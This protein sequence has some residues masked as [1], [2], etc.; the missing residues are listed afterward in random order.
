VVVI[1]AGTNHVVVG[2][3]A[4]D[5]EAPLP[6]HCAQDA[7]QIQLV[8]EAK[9]RG[10]FENEDDCVRPIRGPR[11]FEGGQCARPTVQSHL[12]AEHSGDTLV[13]LDI[14]RAALVLGDGVGEQ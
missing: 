2:A 14:L 13:L 1:S 4:V 9:L 3:V 8:P 10:P 12:M 7:R 6:R 5:D 11:E